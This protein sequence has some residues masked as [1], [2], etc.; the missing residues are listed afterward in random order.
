MVKSGQFA[1]KSGEVESAIRIA[2]EALKSDPN[3]AEAVSLLNAAKKA[4][5]KKIP[6][7]QV[8]ADQ[9]SDRWQ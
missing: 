2:E 1:L 6:D 4:A 5:E 8:H 9:C 7:R 3:N